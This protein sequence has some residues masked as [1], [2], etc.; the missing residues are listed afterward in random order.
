MNSKTLYKAIGAAGHRHQHSMSLG[1]AIG[2]LMLLDAMLADRQ[3]RW[4]DTDRAKS[5][6]LRQC[7]VGHAAPGLPDFGLSC[8]ASIPAEL[9]A[10]PIGVRGDG[11][12]ET[13]LLFLVT[14]PKP[15]TFRAFLRRSNSLLGNVP[16]VALRLVIPKHF[17]WCE[18]D[19][20]GA[21]ETHKLE[22]LGVADS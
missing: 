11:S 20:R 17:R 12:G 13:V 19:L 6:H 14:T 2:R 15:V 5:A 9:R 7:F 18:A 10:M 8:S 1:A 22:L 16:R 21:F 4:L 3:T